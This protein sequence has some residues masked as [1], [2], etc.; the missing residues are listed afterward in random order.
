MNCQ[1]TSEICEVI[2]STINSLFYKIGL[3]WF[4]AILF[5]GLLIYLAVQRSLNKRLKKYETDLEK[6]KTKDIEIW[7]QQ[8]ELMF[9]FVKFLEEEF[10]SN[11]KLKESDATKLK[12]IK[13]EIFAKLNTYYGQLY[14]VM[15]TDIL[16]KINYYINN[17]LS[18]VQRFYLYKEL[19]KQL[20]KVIHEKFSDENCP[21]IEGEANKA[22]I[23][24]NIN[25]Q[26]QR[27]NAENVTELKKHYAFI[28]A[29]PDEK[30]KMLPF[31]AEEE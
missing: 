2:N 6:T 4:L 7:K 19:R 12:N 15:E 27:R 17:T 14:L 23:F 1:L 28:D 30:Y 25:G 24:E 3:W 10:F 18:P 13:S 21:F 8:K 20:M 26:K 16:E 5:L 29:L 31:F 11:P 9:N 22:P